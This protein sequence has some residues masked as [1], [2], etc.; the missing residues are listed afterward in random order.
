MHILSLEV[1][2][3]EKDKHVLPDLDDTFSEKI[4]RGARK[5]DLGTKTIFGPGNTPL[6]K[7]DMEAG[8]E[9]TEKERR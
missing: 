3:L 1:I 2:L 8:R 5:T 6:A 7:V 4:K 9:L